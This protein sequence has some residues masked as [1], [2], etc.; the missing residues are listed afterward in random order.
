M[1]SQRNC[2]KKIRFVDS[3]MKHQLSKK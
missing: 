2:K 1:K 3:M